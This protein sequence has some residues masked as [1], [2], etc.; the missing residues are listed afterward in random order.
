MLEILKKK[1]PG[2]EVYSVY[3]EEFKSFGRVIENID[4]TE[5]INVGE[6][7]PMPETGV[8]YVPSE[9]EFEKLPIAEEV[10]KELFGTLPAQLGYCHGHSSF[11]NATEWHTSSEINIAITPIVLIV[12]HRWEIENDTID[13]SRFRAF[14][15]PKGVAIECFATTLHYCPCQVSDEGFGCAVGLPEATNTALENVTEDK[16]ISARNKWIICH[17]KNQSA[18]ERGI[19]PGITGVNFEIKY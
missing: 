1:N 7:I 17:E 2:L 13:S 9:E 4:T 11:L 10:Q 8:R 5:I 3:D 12:G 6:K 14:Y 15:L 16:L 18:I 19:T